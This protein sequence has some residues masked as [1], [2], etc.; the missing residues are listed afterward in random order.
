MFSHG[1]LPIIIKP[2]RITPHSAT[3]N[4][5]IYTNKLY[6]TY[7]SRI[8]ITDLADHFGIFT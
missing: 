7:K 3:L 6:F 4:D 1:L 5:H 2:T 8:T